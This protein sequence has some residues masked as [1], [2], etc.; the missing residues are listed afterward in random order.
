MF[1]VGDKVVRKA[2]QRNGLWGL[3]DKV[4]T[5]REVIN[6]N[7]HFWGMDGTW[8]DWRFELVEEPAKPAVPGIPDGYR[9]VRVGT[10][11]KGEYVLTSDGGPY[12]TIAE[13]FA[14][15]Y[16]I[17]EPVEPLAPKTKKIKM[18]QYAVKMKNA[19]FMST[20]GEEAPDKS[21][22]W[23]EVPGSEIEVEVP[24]DV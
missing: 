6:T 20:H 11:V 9:L 5:V 21:M 8:D 22:L 13:C 14:K 17:V 18:R 3:G 7:L 1:K 4:L 23:T 10:P 24:D 12:K 19:W 16:V 2:E 15:N